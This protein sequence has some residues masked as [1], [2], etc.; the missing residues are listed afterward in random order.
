MIDIRLVE[1]DRVDPVDVLLLGA[2]HLANPGRDAVNVEFD[3]VL[4]EHRQRQLD[5]MVERLAK[6]GPSKVCVEWMAEEQEAL[7]VEFRQ[8][9]ESPVSPNR[10]EVYQI[11]FRLAQR[12]GL[13]LVH[14]IDA[15]KTLEWDSFRGYLEHHPDDEQRLN[16][17]IA[18]GQTQAQK[19]SERFRSI[20]IS[21]VSSEI[22]ADEALAANLRFYIDIAGL[23]GIGE[24]GGAD[25]A[26]SWYRRNL[27]IFSNLCA[28][29]EPGDRLFVLFGA[30]HVPILRHL[31][32]M[33][34]RHRLV[35]V[36]AFLQ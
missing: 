4:L 27:R 32:G 7:D 11:G 30:G 34:S 18:A 28:I 23:G 2:M 17:T 25:Y 6:F 31:V 14:A 22:N 3:D 19:L 20:P 13:D 26:A 36:L 35:D 16:E 10:S 9:L 1:A 21:D 12:C 29:S 5:D 15:D 33:S 8:Y 24:H